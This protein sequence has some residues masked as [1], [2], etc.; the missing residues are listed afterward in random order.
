MIVSYMI[1]SERSR[2]HHATNRRVCVP[3]ATCA[4]LAT[5]ATIAFASRFMRQYIYTC[6][7]QRTAQHVLSLT[8]AS[9]MEDLDAVILARAKDF[10]RAVAE[11][12]SLECTG[13]E[14]QEMTARSHEA[15]KLLVMFVALESAGSR[16]FRDV[17]EIEVEIKMRA[18]EHAKIPSRWEQGIEHMM[19]IFIRAFTDYF[20]GRAGEGDSVSARVS[21]VLDS[22]DHAF[23]AIRPSWCC[24][25][26]MA[27]LSER[28]LLSFLVK[29]D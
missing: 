17:A 28:T 15:L 14:L 21:D 4:P 27:W 2:S 22:T 5:H 1:T 9:V 26:W 20:A 16:D 11:F 29:S 25:D 13:E 7:F 19:E 3:V 10:V 24:D 18:R 8:R 23:R 12:W 6:S